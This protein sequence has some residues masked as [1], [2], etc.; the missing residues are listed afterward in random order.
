MI[1]KWGKILNKTVNYNIILENKKLMSRVMVFLY[2][3]KIQELND[4]GY[5]CEKYSYN[6]L[7]IKREYNRLYKLWLNDSESLIEKNKRFNR[8][9]SSLSTKYL[10]YIV[11][12]KINNFKEVSEYY[13][14]E[15]HINRILKCF[16]KLENVNYKR[17]SNILASK[18]KNIKVI[19]SDL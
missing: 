10:N 8:Q 14:V 13:T 15:I 4:K 18:I 11:K 6:K 12:E 17:F 5:K 7:E 3:L 16:N 19:S 1:D 9:L 2:N